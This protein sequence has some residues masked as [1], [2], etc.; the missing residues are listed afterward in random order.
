MLHSCF[1]YQVFGIGCVLYSYSTAQF[2]AVIF[3]GLNSPV[4]LVA[5]MLERA[6]LQQQQNLHSEGQSSGPEL[7]QHENIFAISKSPTFYIIF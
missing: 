6:G 3:Q 5:T 1:S 4:W 2:G 7:K